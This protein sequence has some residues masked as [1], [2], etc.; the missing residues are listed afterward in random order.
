[1]V[2]NPLVKAGA[3]GDVSSISGLG[4]I[5]GT[6]HGNTFHILAWRIPGIEGPG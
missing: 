4:R 2:K 1:V 3:K 5:P 6:G